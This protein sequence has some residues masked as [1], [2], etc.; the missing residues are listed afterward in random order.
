MPDPTNPPGLPSLNDLINDGNNPTP[1][2]VP[3]VVPVPPVPPTPPQDP[4]TPPVPPVPPV[5]PPADPPVPGPNDPPV[6]PDNPTD[7]PADDPEEELTVEDF[8]KQVDA[9]H[10]SDIFGQV[11]YGETDPMSAEGIK[12]RDDYIAARAELQ[13]EE[14]IKQADPRAYAY[15]LHRQNGGSDDDFFQVKS[16]VLPAMD[17]LEESVDLQRTVYSEALKAKG[18]TEKQIATLLKASIDSKELLD[19]AKA[20]WKE[21]SDRDKDIAAKASVAHTATVKQHQADINM[22]STA[23]NQVLTTSKDFGYQVADTDKAAFEQAFKDNVYYE[24]GQFWLMKAITTASL[25]K[26]METEL[27]GHLGGKID[28]MIEKQAQTVSARRF[29]TKAKAGETKPKGAPGENTT[30]TLGEL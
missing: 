20:A 30:K 21:I 2:V 18:S 26:I 16:F 29:I 4:P 27:F 28:K 1:P 14:S 8:F 19:D 24:N 23:V 11:Q 12:M 13:F 9:L 10:G 6:D 7:P 15:L 22:L 17:K 25:P 3:P 5:N